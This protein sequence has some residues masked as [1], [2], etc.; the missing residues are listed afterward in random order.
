MD[1]F[2]FIGGFHLTYYLIL[3]GT[4]N[5][6]HFSVTKFFVDSLEPGTSAKVLQ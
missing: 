1:K 3:G 2:F 4:N 6:L 5:V